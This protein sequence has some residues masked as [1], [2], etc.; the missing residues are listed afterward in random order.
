MKQTKYD[1]QEEK[2]ERI[3]ETVFDAFNGQYLKIAIGKGLLTQD[4]LVALF[5]RYIDVLPS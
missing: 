5:E 4:E 3:S 1:S 2:Y